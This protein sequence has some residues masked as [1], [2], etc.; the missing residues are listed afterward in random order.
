[1]S[2]IL[3]SEVRQGLLNYLATKPYREVAEAI[4]ALMT[5]RASPKD[6]TAKDAGGQMDGTASA[7]RD[8]HNA[9]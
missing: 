2:F 4:D 9:G 6:A 7:R 3:P 1:M 5:L 8:S